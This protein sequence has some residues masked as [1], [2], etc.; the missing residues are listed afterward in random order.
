L[1]PFLR[2]HGGG[3]EG[4]ASATRLVIGGKRD[5]WPRRPWTSRTQHSCGLRRPRPAEQGGCAGGGAP[6]GPDAQSFPGPWPFEVRRAH[7][8]EGRVQLGSAHGRGGPSGVS[9]LVVAVRRGSGGLWGGASAPS[10]QQV[11][12]LRA[13]LAWSPDPPPGRGLVRRTTAVWSESGRGRRPIKAAGC[14]GYGRGHP[15]AD[16]R[17][18]DIGVSS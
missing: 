7:L 18:N 15:S 16:S 8:R 11:R 13:D 17:S 4:A 12:Q 14:R 5:P 3:G 10:P 9:S 2:G 6:A 1:T